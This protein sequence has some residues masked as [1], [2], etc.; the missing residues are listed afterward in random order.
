[1][2]RPR[3]RVLKSITA[4]DMTLIMGPRADLLVQPALLWQAMR[5]ITYGKSPARANG[6]ASAWDNR[7][8]SDGTAAIARTTLGL[9]E[10][11]ARTEH[12]AG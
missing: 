10:P 2:G 1:M 3:G 8:D 9:V 7:L 12:P 5:T 4:E 6:V 11:H